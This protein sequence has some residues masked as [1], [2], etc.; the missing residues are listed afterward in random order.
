MRGG[1]ERTGA[2]G[3]LLKGRG[4]EVREA[5]DWLMPVRENVRRG[6]GPSYDKA[7]MPPYGTRYVTASAIVGPNPS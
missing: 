5:C 4:I 1:S 6:S 7:T 3:R 2:V